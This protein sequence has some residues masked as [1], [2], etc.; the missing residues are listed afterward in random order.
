M[1]SLELA[2]TAELHL[3]KTLLK[4]GNISSASA[5][6]RYVRTI[7]GSSR[8]QLD[9]ASANVQARLFKS[10]PVREVMSEVLNS[11]RAILG[12]EE[13][14]AVKKK[15][16]RAKDYA[17]GV[18]DL[19]AGPTVQRVQQLSM[20]ASPVLSDR[21]DP[22][23][24]REI[25]RDQEPD[26]G[27]ENEDD[28]D[29]YASRLATFS[30]GHLGSGDSE[31]ESDRGKGLN[32]NSITDN[33][34]SE[35]EESEVSEPMDNPRKPKKPPSAAPNSTTFL[36]SLSMGYFSGSESAEDLSD[37][38]PKART[39]RMGQQARRALW[40]KKFGKNANHVKMQPQDRDEGWDARKGAS[41]G[42]DRGK[43]GRGRGRGDSNMTGGRAKA[44]SG[45]GPMSSGANSD[46]VA[47][48]EAKSVTKTKSASDGPIHPSW[49]AARKAKEQK[50]LVQFQGKKVVF[51]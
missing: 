16:L 2:S 35:E 37:E 5:L 40:E 31:S 1:Q 13:V 33:S 36:P 3:Y 19:G 18:T 50:K 26:F 10:G 28:Y 9:D 42:D 48:R 6:P 39:N 34:A 21:D 25:R 11:V 14:K 20:R 32:P 30:D 17:M 47:L 51:D 49:E 4:F 38:G 41:A 43:R 23:G 29:R 27:T 45:R 7:V 22:S 15:R 8:K 44:R 46:P 12:I 24:R